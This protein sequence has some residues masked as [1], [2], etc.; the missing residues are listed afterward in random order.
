MYVA[1]N[2]GLLVLDISDPRDPF[3][4]GSEST[5]SP[6][7]D[8]A[9]S[10]GYAYVAVRDI[11]LQIIDVTDP[12]NPSTTGSLAELG[13][14]ASCVTVAGEYAYV[15][16]TEFVGSARLKVI[17]ISDPL[18]PQVVG[19]SGAAMWI[20][21]I[22]DIEVSGDHAFAATSQGIL[23]FDIADPQNPRIIGNSV[24]GGFSDVVA[25]GERIYA[26]GAYGLHTLPLQC[27]VV[28]VGDD[29]GHLDRNTPIA[30]LSLDIFPNPF[31]PQT[32][33][34]FSLPQAGWTE[35]GVYDLNGRQ[36]TT[37]AS[38]QFD[39]G[40]HTINWTGR[41]SGGRAVPSGTYIVRLETEDRVESK[42]V[43]L[44]R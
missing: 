22:G 11:L 17:D 32:T 23:V 9:V 36:V 6:A 37:L 21:S 5:A 44:V 42:K 30:G 28:G 34:S 8:V 2:S 29:T 7:K 27:G 35:V 39:A 38:R 18:S 15:G 19:S 31:N 20:Y 1:N 25:F 4:V 10:G 12:L 13:L 43:M 24:M 26:C 3:I 40:H 33:V 16:A 14:S 41:D